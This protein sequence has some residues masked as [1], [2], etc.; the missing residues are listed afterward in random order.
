MGDAS[1]L[2]K[3]NHD[4]LADLKAN[5]TTLNKLKPQN[6]DYLLVLDLEGKVEILEFPVL[7]INA[8][9]MDFVDSFHRYFFLELESFVCFFSPFYHSVDEGSTLACLVLVFSPS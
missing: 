8:K 2:E 4:F 6:L 3:F 1:H 5:V 9:S 7:M